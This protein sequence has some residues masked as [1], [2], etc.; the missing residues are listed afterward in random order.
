MTMTRIYNVVD[1]DGHVL[2]P[3]D[4]WVRYIDPKFRDRAPKLVV[5]DDGNDWLAMGEKLVGAPNLGVTRAGAVDISVDQKMRYADGKRGGFDPH[6]RIKDL[7]LDGIDAVV[8]YPTLGLHSGSLADADLAAAICRAYNR[9]IVDYCKPYPD[10]LFGAAILPMQSVE[11][12]V[13][14]MRFARKELGLRSGFI[15]PNPYNNRL[16]SDR[17]YD[18]VWEEAQELDF[19]LGIHEGT[20][21]MKAIAVDRVPDWASQHIVS[22]TMEMMLASLNLIWGGVCERFPS[23]RFGFLESGGGWMAAWLDRM[24]RHFVRRG[25]HG[26]EFLKLKP[27][28]YFRRQCWISFEP[29]E[30]TIAYAAEYLGAS[31][32]LWAT[33]YPHSDGFFPGAPQMV[34]RQI[35]QDIR[36]QVLAQGAIDFYGLH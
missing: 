32:I 7:D 28:E 19:A 2:E 14:E 23:V 21:G 22:H 29:V 33:D 11:H 13:L 30:G 20:G 17:A 27:S 35:P 1:A 12:M 9:W 10:R 25:V 31:K 4:L 16:L 18:P 6:A 34:A 15:R 3:P 24:D 36:R 5:G 8:L 26:N